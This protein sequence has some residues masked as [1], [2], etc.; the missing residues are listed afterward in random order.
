MDVGIQTGGSMMVGA[1]DTT[2]LWR[3]QL[4]QMCDS[5]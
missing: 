2:E 3:H 4:Q 5:L 1:D